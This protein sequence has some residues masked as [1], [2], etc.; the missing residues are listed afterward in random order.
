MSIS[1]G[2]ITITDTTDLG[3]LSVYLTANTVRQQVYDDNGASTVYY[4]NWD[5]QTGGT[6]LVITPHVYFNGH[7]ESLSSNKIAVAWGKTENGTTYPYGT[8]QYQFFPCSSV[9]TNCPESVAGTTS[10]ELQRPTN[11]SK[12]GT[13]A[14][15]TAT[16]TYYPV[17]SDRSITLQ[18]VATLDLTI[19]SNGI[20]GGQGTAAKSLQLIGDGSHFTYTWDGTA[21]APTTINLI[22]EK[23]HIDGIHWYCDN[24]LISGLTALN[25]AVT[26]NNIS[27]Y[28]PTFNTKKSA[29]FKIVETDSN[30]NEV[31]NG[32]VDY[33]TIYKLEEARPGDSVYAAYLD[34]DEE[35]VSEYN[36]VVE[37]DNAETTFF[38]TKNGVNDLTQNS[39]WTLTISDSNAA[40]A[41]DAQKDIIYTTSNVGD[42]YSTYLNHVKVTTLRSN[43]AWIEFTASKSGVTSLIKRFTI[44]KNPQLISR[45]LRLDSVNSNRKTNGTYEPSTITIDAIERTG[46][47]TNPYHIAN[48]LHY[49]IYY[50]SGN[51]SSFISNTSGTALQITLADGSSNRPISYIETFLGGTAANNY[52]DAEDK[53]KITI[54]SDGTDGSPGDSP[55]NFMITNVFDSISTDFSNVTSQ[56]FPIKIPVKATQGITVK[57]IRHG[58]STYPLITADTILNSSSIGP[59]YYSGDS[60]VTST[61]G[62]IVDN[63]RYNI[64]AGT[65]IG[66][67]GNIVLT[68]TYESGKTLTQ[69]YS[70][71]AQPEILKPVRLLLDASPSDTFENQEGQI[72]ITPTVLSG[73]TPITSGLS[74]FIWEA[75]IEN[76]STHQL[77]WTTISSTDTDDDIY[78]SGHNVVVKGSAV[79]GYLSFRLTVRVSRGGNTEDYTEYITLKD[80]DDPLQVTLHSTVGEQLVNGQGVG[81]LYARVIRRGDN[82][83]YDLIVPDDMLAVG[84]SAPTSATAPG[85]TGYFH[86]VQSGSP[87]APTGQINYYSRS[88]GS[89]SWGDPRSAAQQKYTYTWYFR[90]SSNTP[91]VDD[92]TT[93]TPIRYAMN[94]NTQFVYISSATVNNKITA[95]V[96]VEL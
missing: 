56:S 89:G 27:N 77:T 41:T 75:Y 25:L 8:G 42:A 84:T 6:A 19:A 71:K 24:T 80:I 17:D 64:P 91:Y 16:I 49:K 9:D 50:A 79:Q 37:L 1:Y 35:T 65:N 40:G 62:A 52:A 58:G 13:G 69:T 46:G 86:I 76:S 90:D 31:T 53:Q 18:A 61:T 70:Y 88:S 68:L 32:F 57:D 28:S 85:K 7:S 74:N 96:K 34:N 3:Q 12:N 54:S 30:G 92:S 4:P 59:K 93:P 11:L 55:W 94:N 20:D 45:A 72:T 78:L 14:T 22:V 87:A 26:T 95:V 63:I 10:K 51:P 43:T 67:A 15:Y 21:L 23:Q 73:T 29:Q 38:L 81:V 60:D 2:T 82:E 36:G 33:Y 83:D 44:T 39:G 5:P 66:A 47:G 48:T